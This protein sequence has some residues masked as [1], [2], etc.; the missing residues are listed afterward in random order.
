[1]TGHIRERRVRGG[2]DRKRADRQAIESIGEVHRVRRGDEHEDGER[3]VP[4]AQF[5]NEPLEERKNEP[6]V[7][8]VVLGQHQQDDADRRGDQNLVAHLVARTQPVVRLTHDLHVIVGEPDAAKRRRRPHRDPHEGVGQ[9][10]PQQRGHERRGEDE[11]PAHG[12]RP[13]F[14]AVGR[15]SFLPDHL[16]DLK[17][18]KRPD[19]PWPERQTDRERRQT[20]RRGPERDVPRDV[21]H[22][23]LRVERVQQLVQH[24]ANS[25]LSRSVTASVPTPR[26]PF[27]STRS[28]GSIKCAARSAASWLVTT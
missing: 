19:H 20:R 5:R 16:A 26:D 23:E 18:V 11:Q 22:G 10:R 17:L 12:R 13:G 24:Q 14:R 9:V 15:R 28:P 21:Q 6:R 2:G 7:V 27:T 25:A 3:Q 8:D 1:M 4:P